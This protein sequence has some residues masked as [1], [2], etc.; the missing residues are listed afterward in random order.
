MFEISNMRRCG[1]NLNQILEESKKCELI[2]AN[3]HFKLHY[4]INHGLIV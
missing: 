3:C 2:C 1:K 4:N